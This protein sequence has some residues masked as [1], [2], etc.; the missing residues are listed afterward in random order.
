MPHF[1]YGNSVS[2]EFNMIS[3]KLINRALS[4]GKYVKHLIYFAIHVSTTV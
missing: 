2:S 1:L 3:Y 4:Y